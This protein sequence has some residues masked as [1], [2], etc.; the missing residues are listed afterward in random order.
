LKILIEMMIEHACG[1]VGIFDL[2]GAHGGIHKE[3]NKDTK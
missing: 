2:G 3:K 1:I